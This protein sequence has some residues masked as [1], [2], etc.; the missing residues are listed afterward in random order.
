MSRKSYNFGPKV[1]ASSQT[2]VSRLYVTLSNLVPKVLSLKEDH[3][4]WDEEMTK[5][6]D[7]L[8]LAI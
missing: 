5:K 6:M 7:K 1:F 4:S 3:G 8:E 2:M